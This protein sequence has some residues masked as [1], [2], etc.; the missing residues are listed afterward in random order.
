MSL[1]Y[2]PASEPQ[3]MSLTYEPASEPQVMSLTYGPAS[4][5]QVMQGGI[6]EAKAREE[7]F[8]QQARLPPTEIGILCVNFRDAGNFKHWQTGD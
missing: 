8:K 3:V 5:P 1:A 6:T 7:K 2:E 4:E